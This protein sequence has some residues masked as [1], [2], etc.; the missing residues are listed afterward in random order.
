MAKASAQFEYD[1]SYPLGSFWRDNWVILQAVHML[2]GRDKTLKVGDT[3]RMVVSK[4]DGRETLFL[5]GDEVD[6]ISQILDRDEYAWLID[7]QAAQSIS[8]KLHPE[9]YEDEDEDAGTP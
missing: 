4:D 3:L 2:V 9:L 1:K 8:R 5:Q 7:E 6:L